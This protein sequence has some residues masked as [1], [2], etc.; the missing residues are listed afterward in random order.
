MDLQKAGLD[1]GNFWFYEHQDIEKLYQLGLTDYALQ[2]DTPPMMFLTVTTLKDPSKMHDGYHTCEAFTFVSYD[3]FKEYQH[4]ESGKKEPG[5]EGLK[6]DIAW[7]MF[8][9]LEKRIPGIS[10]HIVFW[11]IGTPLTNEHYLNATY[12]NLYGIEK[13][14]TQVGPGAFSIK[15]EFD[16]LFLCGAS[17]LSHGV[18]GAT[19]SGL[20]VAKTILGCKTEDLLKHNGPPI[21]IYPSEDTSQ[22][23]EHLQKKIKNGRR[24]GS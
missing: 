21:Q 18:S 20:A 10:K 24:G 2:A 23:P 12:G 5:Y 9:G 22:W 11:E 3:P 19:E 7:R 17:T 6:E 13:S 4:R 1:S 16:G 15:T 14:V 8:N